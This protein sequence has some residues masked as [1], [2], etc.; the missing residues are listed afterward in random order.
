MISITG[1]LSRLIGTPG[2]GVTGTGG[3]AGTPLAGVRVRVGTLLAGGCT[4]TPTGGVGIAVGTP[5]AGDPACAGTGGR[6]TP[7]ACAHPAEQNAT[8]LPPRT[9]TNR[10]RSGST[11]LLQA[12]QVLVMGVPVRRLRRARRSTGRHTRASDRD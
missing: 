12:G 3:P 8:T 10:E 4:G 2:A 5:V 6:S 11:A 1:P 9:A 7:C